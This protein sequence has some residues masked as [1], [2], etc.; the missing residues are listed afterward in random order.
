MEEKKLLP[1]ETVVCQIAAIQWGDGR[2]EPVCGG[3]LAL[4]GNL[5]L[6]LGDVIKKT[7]WEE[8]NKKSVNIITKPGIKI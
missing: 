4:A 1:S 8:M 3:N 2:I 7:L 6:I 5:Y